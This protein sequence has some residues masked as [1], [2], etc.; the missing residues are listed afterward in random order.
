MKNKVVAGLLGIFLGGFGV[1]KFYL[2]QIGLGVVYL[3]FCWTTIPGIIGFIEGIIIS[4][5][6]MKTLIKNTITPL[7]KSQGEY[8][9]HFY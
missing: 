2:G 6:A 9:L 5:Q 8:P 7:K 3:L 4:Q 1:H